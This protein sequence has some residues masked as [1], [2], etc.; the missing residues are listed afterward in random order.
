MTRQIPVPSVGRLFG[1][2]LLLTV[3]MLGAL[4]PEAWSQANVKGQWSVAS[5]TMPINPIHTALLR[6]GK[7]LVVAGSGNCPPSQSGC[8]S[9]APYGPANSSGALLLDP[10]SGSITQFTNSWDLFCNSMTVLADGRVFING[11]TIQ[12]DPFYGQPKSTIFDP[13][14]NSFTD[15]QNMAHG[16]WYPTVITLGDGRVLT[17]SGINESG[18]TDSAVEIY[19]VGTGW[20]TQYGA[21]FTPPLYPRLHLLPNGKVFYSGWGRVSALFD[22]SNTTWTQNVATTVYGGTRTYG[23]AV[24]L[25]LTPANGYDPKVMILGGNSPATA[26]TEIID[27]GAG[28]PKWVSGPSMSQPRI[29]MNAVLLPNGKV[30]ALGGST[31]DEDTGSLSLNADLYDPAPNT[32]SSAGANASQRLYHSVALLLPDATVWLAGGNPSRGTYNHSVEIYQPAYLFQS[33]GTLA[34]RPSISNAPASISYGSPFTVQTPDAANISSVVLMKNGSVTHAFNMD[35]RLV[36][37]SFTAGSGSLTVTGPPSGNIAPPGYYMLFLLNS[38]GVPSVATMVNLAQGG[39]PA[40]PTNVTATVG[41]AQVALSWSASSGATSYNVKRSTTS[42]GPYTTVGSPTTPG[43]T[44][45]GLTN[46]TTYYYVVTAVNGSGESGNSSQVSATPSGSV[47]GSVV[48]DS[49]SSGAGAQRASSL[50][51]SHTVGS[52]ANL[53][54]VVGVVGNCAPSVTYGGVALTHAGQVYNNN[55]SPGSTDLFV[56]ANPAAG[57]NTVQVTYSGCTSDVEA[58]ST[59]FTGVN[60]STPLAHVSTNF[61]SGATAQVAVASVAGDMVVDV[62]GN[63]G[64]ITSSSQSLSWLK[65]QNGNTA[66]GNG[67]QSTAAG[68]SSVTMGYAVAADW[69]GII[70][71]DVVAASTS[72][73]PPSAPTNVTA[74]AG[75]AQVALSWSASSGASSYNVKRSTTSGGPYTTVGS[76]TNPGYTNTGLTNGTTYYYVVTAVNGSGESGNSS[77]VS[78]TPQVAAPS[79]PT[80]VTATVGNAQVA[81]SWSASSGATS[82]N[83]KRS[84]TSGGPYTTVGSP[85]TPGYTNTGLTNG[86]TYYYVVT[87][88]NGSGESGNSSQVSATPSGSVSGSVVLDSSSSGAGAQRASSLSWSHTVGSGAN[89]ALVVG[90]VGNCA[91]SVTYGG[92]ALTHAGQVYNNNRSPGST[93]LFVLANP[94]AGTN[95]VQVTYSGC[96]SDVE[97]GSTSFTGVNQSTPLAHVSTNFGSGATAQVAVASVAGDMVVDVVGNGGVITSSSQ[98][99]SWLKNQNGNTAAGN[100]AQSTAAGASSVTMGYAV[101]ADWWGIIGADVVA[102]STSSSP[103]SAP[104]NV[105]ATAGNAQVALS[106]SASSGASSYNVKRSTTSGGPYTTVGSPTNPGYTNT[107]LTNGTTYYYVVTAVNG[108]GESGNS[109]QVSAAPAAGTTSIDYGSGFTA[110]GIKLNGSASLNGTRLRVTSSTANQGGSAFFTTAANVQSF[111]TD[112]S[113]QLTSPDADGMAFVI[114]SNGTAA[115]GPVG[116]GL[117]YGPDNAASAPYAG[118]NKSV[119]VK[120]DLYSNGTEGANSTGLYTGGASPTTPAID[121][122]SSGVDLHSGDVFNVH[123]SYDGTTL[124]MSLTDATTLAT[125]NTS[126]TV[127]IPAAVGGN[128][129]FVGFTGGTGGLTATQEVLNW[130]Y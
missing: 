42:G 83:V 57:T 82:Y 96:T 62:V 6:N 20:S 73:S 105:T 43:Y 3:F 128:T 104:T 18:S 103:P 15:T 65:N 25:G 4:V 99:L 93:D 68:A 23:S 125:F 63:G 1:Y 29:E 8:P 116:G 13:S 67:A 11:G 127:N 51:W 21:P 17:W 101:A 92:V 36:G 124:T 39:T 123:M 78:A 130:T 35:Q 9:G 88:V 72:S 52:G 27:M 30:L 19:T 64:V 16:R 129:A 45:T 77:Q 55:R 108:S 41:N 109:S 81:L 86:T 71:A 115:L 59:S 85:T 56:L 60:Q 49:S 34:T 31:N 22:P 119:A 48:L 97:A 122:T 75:N 118:M 7:I 5:Y 58:G 53:A 14:N 47:S 79:A 94:A 24:L 95:T 102:A 114:Q 120:F 121:L 66:A 113:F 117:G 40:A 26:T 28:S 111:T 80:N 106:W 100:G 10:A 87:A 38:A 2:L 76:P 126:W 44:N 74:T 46:G 12:Y 32:F 91:P 89:L 70:G 98:S 90:V 50:S 107:G 37:V 61:G 84:T 110:T 69:W 54:L 112:F 33:N